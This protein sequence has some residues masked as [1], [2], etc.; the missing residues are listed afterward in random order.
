MRADEGFGRKGRTGIISVN[1]ALIDNEPTLIA[2]G[3]DNKNSGTR[4]LIT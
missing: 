3:L 2:N 1:P 4:H